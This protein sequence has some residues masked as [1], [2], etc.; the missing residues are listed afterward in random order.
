MHELGVG[1]EYE[2]KAIEQNTK[3]GYSY[4]VLDEIDRNQLQICIYSYRKFL[5]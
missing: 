3:Y 5:H 1:I 4:K 2:V